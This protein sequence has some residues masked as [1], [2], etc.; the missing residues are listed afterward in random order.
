MSPP[1]TSSSGL[2]PIS[3]VHVSIWIQ[4]LGHQS[5]LSYTKI[6]RVIQPK[7]PIFVV[8]LVPLPP[9][10]FCLLSPPASIHPS[11]LC[12]QGATARWTLSFQAD[13][14]I[15]EMLIPHALSTQRGFMMYSGRQH[16]LHIFPTKPSSPCPSLP[17][18]THPL[19]SPLKLPN[20]QFFSFSLQ[21]FVDHYRRRSH[22]GCHLSKQ[23]RRGT[24]TGEG[25]M[26]RGR[27][28]REPGEQSGH[29]D[30]ENIKHRLGLSN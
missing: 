25:Q 2:P 19:P 1:L 9:F 11:L 28:K 16:H 13:P 8:I 7:F 12:Q 14:G 26:D 3:P 27:V 10:P 6:S 18:P 22:P 20:E 15:G 4:T 24:A 21:I 17:L 29:N 23:N 5:R 30:K